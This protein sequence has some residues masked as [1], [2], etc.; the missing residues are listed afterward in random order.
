M[1][2]KRI[3]VI[4]DNDMLDILKSIA[5]KAK[6]KNVEVD[7]DQLNVGGHIE[8]AVLDASNNLDIEKT[9]KLLRERFQNKHFDIVACDY[10]LSVQNIDGVE[11]LRRIGRDCFHKRVRYIIYSGLLEDILREKIRIGCDIDP[12]VSEIKPK[13]KLIKEIKQLVNSNYLAFVGREQLAE[14]ILNF[15]KNDITIDDVFNELATSYPERRFAYNFVN[16]MEGKTLR[17]VKD[18]I[19]NDDNLRL[20]FMKGIFEQSILYFTERVTKR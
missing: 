7:Y 3:L 14:T 1:I 4:D 19:L 17:E 11:L 20:E 13:D 12:E 8:P 5:K 9:K 2:H 16:G 15:L 10:D 6:S 18:M